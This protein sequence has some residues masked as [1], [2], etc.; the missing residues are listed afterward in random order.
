MPK[1]KSKIKEIKIWGRLTSHAYSDLEKLPP[2]E[3][4]IT[5]SLES[6]E[7]QIKKVPG[8]RINLVLTVKEASNLL[9]LIHHFRPV[10]ENL[11]KKI[12]EFVRS[13]K[14]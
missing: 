2:H 13:N 3:A 6:L 10:S 11:K 14:K 8:L 7:S 1:E 9:D 4:E 5:I 12:G